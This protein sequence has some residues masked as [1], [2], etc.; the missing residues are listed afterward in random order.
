VSA[1]A[2]AHEE[3]EIMKRWSRRLGYL[4]LVA[5]AGCASASGGASK[6]KESLAFPESTVGAGAPRFLRGDAA[7]VAASAGPNDWILIAEQEE[8]ANWVVRVYTH[9]GQT[10]ANWTEQITYMNTG[11]PVDPPAD[12]ASLQHANLLKKCPSASWSV[13]SVS[14]SEVLYESKV[15]GCASMTDQDSITRAIYGSENLFIVS[16]VAKVKD[17]APEKRAEA[18]RLLSEFQLKPAS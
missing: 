2:N 12:F 13:V 6:S 1:A 16:Y 15:T 11:K 14:D 10:A 3:G 8:S 9:K 17:L 7:D 4:A 18:Y 5:I